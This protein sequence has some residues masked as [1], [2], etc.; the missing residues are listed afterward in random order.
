MFKF[1]FALT[2]SFLAAVSLPQFYNT[3]VSA[4]V[5]ENSKS[6]VENNLSDEDL[7]ALDN[8][9]L[10]Y[11]QGHECDNNNRPLCAAN[12]NAM[13]SIYDG[14]AMLDSDDK[15]CITFDQGYENGYTPAILDT[16]KEKE[17]KAVFFLT[18]DYAERNPELVKRMI[19]EGHII[20]NHGLDHASLPKLSLAEA[21]SEIMEL[22]NFVADKYGYEMTYFRP[23]CGEYSERSIALAQRLGYKTF[24]WSFAYCD[25]DPNDQPNPQKAFEKITKAAHGGEILLLH[26]VSKTNCEILGSVID[27]LRAQGYEISLPSI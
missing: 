20:G 10:G 16:L 13:Y 17:A 11:G 25:W 1:I 8:N 15:I 6:K 21:E 14:Y 7:N 4:Y 23:P 19:D 18:G 12:F 26:S 24:L 5:T 3:S 2:A 9:C 22:H 27:D